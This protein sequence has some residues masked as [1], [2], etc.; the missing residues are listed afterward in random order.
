[1][2]VASICSFWLKLRSGFKLIRCP[3]IVTDLSGIHFAQAFPHGTDYQLVTMTSK[4]KWHTDEQLGDVGFDS[5]FRLTNIKQLIDEC[6]NDDES[7]T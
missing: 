4:I 6:T 5:D 7:K 1:M 3:K 2:M